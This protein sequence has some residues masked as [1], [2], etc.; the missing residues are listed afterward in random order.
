MLMDNLVINVVVNISGTGDFPHSD[1]DYKSNMRTGFIFNKA[2]RKADGVMLQ[3]TYV[4]F[5]KQKNAN[6]QI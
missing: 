6:S 4:F 3:F 2:F 1:T 5:F